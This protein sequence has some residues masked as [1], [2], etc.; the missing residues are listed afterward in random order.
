[1]QK[2]VKA[3]TDFPQLGGP[4]NTSIP[5]QKSF[6]TLFLKCF[7]SSNL[8]KKGLGGGAGKVKVTTFCLGALKKFLTS[9]KNPPCT[10]IGRDRS[11][12]FCARD[13]RNGAPLKVLLEEG[14]EALA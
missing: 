11:V 10:T 12:C 3:L 14:K 5:Q 8:L 6:T 13:G 9:S 2:P 7:C 1:M 4:S